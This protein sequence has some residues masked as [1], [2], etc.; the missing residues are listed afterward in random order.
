M[1]KSLHIGRYVSDPKD[2]RVLAEFL[3]AIGFD[4]VAADG[5][6]AMVSAP[7]ALLSLNRLL[8]IEV[9]N[10]DVVF[11]I[12]QQR[13]FKLLA[14]AANPKTHERS[15]SLELPGGIVLSIHGRPEEAASALEGQLNAAGK[16][17]AIVVSRFNA[18]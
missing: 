3:Q 13:K 18:F 4:S 14:D 17:F 10:P 8:V 11:G 7:H 5:K 1:L 16:R 2:L 15:F 9:T 6:S 12:A